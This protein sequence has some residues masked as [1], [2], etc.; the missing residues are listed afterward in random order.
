MFGCVLYRLFITDISLNITQ[1]LWPIPMMQVVGV[2]VVVV[3]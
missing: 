3:Q 2:A 1:R